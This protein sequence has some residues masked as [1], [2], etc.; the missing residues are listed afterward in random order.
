MH[1]RRAYQDALIE[2]AETAERTREEEARRRVDEERLRI[3][4][5]LH[6]MVAHSLVAINVQAG[7][8]AHVQDPDPEQT[9]RPS[10]HQAGQRRGVG[11]P[12]YDARR[13][14]RAGDA[15]AAPVRPRRG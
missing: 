5:D 8:A 9:R 13:A 15:E 3:A 4:R 10:R 12:A 11:R 7:V 6:D 1:D 2:R 14:A